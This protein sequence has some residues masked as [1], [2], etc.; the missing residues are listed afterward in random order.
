VPQTEIDIL[1]MHGTAD[2]M[3]PFAT[4]EDQRRRVVEIYGMGPGREI[5]ADA[6]FT[7][8]GFQN[9]NGTVFELLQHDYT[10]DNFI[11]G[12]H[13]Y[14]GSLDHLPTEPGQLMGYGCTGQSSFH[15]GQEVMAFFLAHPKE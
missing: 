14:P 8:T 1:Y 13:C 11:L 12:G 15:W 5:A 2:A 4:G 9:A 6:N 3:V 10:A 7:R